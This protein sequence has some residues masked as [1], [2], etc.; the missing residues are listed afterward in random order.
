MRIDHIGVAVE[1]IEEAKHFYSVILGLVVSDVE[2]IDSM[3]VRVAFFDFAL[4]GLSSLA[5]AKLITQAL[6][7]ERL[8]TFLL[9]VLLVAFGA[10][11]QISTLKKKRR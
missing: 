5:G 8:T 7:F 1:S 10:A 3:G 11:I 9:F 6:N 2:E 4:I